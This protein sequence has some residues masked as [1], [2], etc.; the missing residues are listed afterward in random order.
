MSLNSGHRKGS[1]FSNRT[2]YLLADV[3]TGI[4]TSHAKPLTAMQAP[5]INTLA[6]GDAV[7]RHKNSVGIGSG[8]VL[9]GDSTKICVPI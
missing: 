4:S 3:A 6:P 2:S 9:L 1:T 5:V 7:W 8:N